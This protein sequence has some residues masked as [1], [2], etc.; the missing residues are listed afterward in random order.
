MDNLPG[1][2]LFTYLYQVKKKK[3]IIMIL[4]NFLGFVGCFKSLFGCDII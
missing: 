1:F 3:L 4:G 2:F